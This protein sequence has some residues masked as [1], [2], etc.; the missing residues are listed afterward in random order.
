MII[1][2]ENTIFF[3]KYAS[4]FDCILISF[5][6]YQCKITYIQMYIYIDIYYIELLYDIYFAKT[7]IIFL[8][9]NI[10]I[11]LRYEYIYTYFV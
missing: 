3:D 8:Q 7:F 11:R 10:E 2:F 5:G 1:I 6:R 4:V 9:R